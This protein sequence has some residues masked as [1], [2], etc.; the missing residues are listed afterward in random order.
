MAAHQRN[1]IPKSP[2]DL[3]AQWRDRAQLLSNYGDPNSARLWQTAAVELEQ[4]LQALSGH[5]LVIG[6]HRH[7]RE[8]GLGGQ[9]SQLRHTTGGRCGPV[10][11]V[12]ISR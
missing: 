11:R 1:N 4:A 3:P 5:Q 12:D 6:D 9:I 8:G 7:I 2:G 10:S